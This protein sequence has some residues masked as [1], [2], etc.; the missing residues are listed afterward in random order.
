MKLFLCKQKTAYEIYQC[1]WSSD[2]CSSDL[3]I[4]LEKQQKEK[5]V[6]LHIR[7]Q[8]GAI[9][10]I[11]LDLPIKAYDKYRY[12]QE[13]VD[14]VRKMAKSL[15]DSQIAESFNQEGRLSSTGKP[16]SKSMISWIRYIHSIPSV[17]L[18]RPEEQT[19]KQIMKKFGV[20]R[21]VVYYWIERE[22]IQARKVNKGTPF[23]ITLNH[24]NEKELENWV[25]TSK[26]L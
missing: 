12:P 10:D 20:S 15:S 13:T 2:V 24:K 4:T 14:T 26:R 16:F 3:D 18:K 17:Q 22:V 6:V 25:K 1:D 23:W 19:V 7:W 5:K 9:E 11:K 21:H 8:G